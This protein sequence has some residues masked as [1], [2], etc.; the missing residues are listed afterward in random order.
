MKRK[1]EY[2]P[3][4]MMPALKKAKHATTLSLQ[5]QEAIKAAHWEKEE[6]DFELKQKKLA[7]QIRLKEGRA[8]SL[9]LIYYLLHQ[10]LDIAP[11]HVLQLPRHAQ[12]VFDV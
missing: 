3:L 8:R 1:N 5:E 10:E 6:Q 2:N 11:Q 7:I 4:M 12:I 9:D